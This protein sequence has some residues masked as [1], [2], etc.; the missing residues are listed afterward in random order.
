[1][2]LACQLVMGFLLLPPNPAP[3]HAD[4]DGITLKQRLAGVDAQRDA[5]KENSAQLE[6]ECLNLLSEESS[7][8]DR[9][10]VYTQIARIYG[11]R[12]PDKAISYGAKALQLSLDVETTCKV[13]TVIADALEVKRR[14]AHD[15]EAR[16]ITISLWKVCLE[17]LDFVLRQNPPA[18]RRD[19]PAVNRFDCGADDE[20]CKELIEKHRQEMEDRKR[21]ELDNELVLYRG[22]FLEK[23]G[24]LYSECDDETRAAL[25]QTAD[26]LIGNG[27]RARYLLA[28]IMHKGES[29]TQGEK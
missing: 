3:A 29:G 14:V 13:H 21:V 11:I 20:A 12:D 15:E 7:P 25:R 19:V 9:G 22:I 27:Q 4:A 1:M 6:R 16:E 24:A 17:G 18:A 28:L 23:C 5:R 10:L 2:L 8:A 26:R